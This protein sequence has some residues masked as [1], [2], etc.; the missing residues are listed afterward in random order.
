MKF[1]LVYFM[2]F[3]LVC[4]ALVVPLNVSAETFNDINVYEKELDKI[5][6][7][8][9]TDYAFP[10][11]DVVEEGAVSKKELSKFYSSMS[12][13]E[14]RKYVMDAHNNEIKSKN[15]FDKIEN[16]SKIPVLKSTF[17]KKQKFYYYSDN[18]LSINA[19]V[20]RADGKERYSS[21]SNG[22]YYHN[23]YPYLKPTSF[24][25]NFSS[26]NTKVNCNYTCT[27]YIAANLINGT[28]YN[29][30]V[31]FDASGGNVYNSIE[32]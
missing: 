23:C 8:L 31:T 11:D 18:Y 25:K 5:N 21:V 27:K 15:S 19:K 16:Y 26:G 2:T 30:S 32:V 7:E 9:G 29:V 13:N 22:E 12:I 6:K 1:K 14:F 4:S 28:H 20:Y 17:S 24:S 3:V 10:T